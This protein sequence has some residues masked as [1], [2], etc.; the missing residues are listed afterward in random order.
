MVKPRIIAKTRKAQKPPDAAVKDT[1]RLII[2][3]L[4]PPLRQMESVMA[5]L[6]ILSQATEPIE[7]AALSAPAQAGQ[8]AHEQLAGQWQRA[9]AA[10]EQG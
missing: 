5:L 2:L 4:E 6:T 8:A 7:P 1:V 9:F 3:E 10:I